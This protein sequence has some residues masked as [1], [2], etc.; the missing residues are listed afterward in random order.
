MNAA[1][2]IV[3]IR[4]MLDAGV[5]F[6]HR[7]KR[8]NPKM[9]PYIYMARSGIYIIHL[10]KT[11][12]LFERAYAFA[13]ELSARGEYLV[14]IGTKKQA[15][16]IVKEEAERC[17]MFYVNVRWLGGTLTN[18]KTV[19]ESIRRLN[20]LEAI[21][22]NE[23]YQGRP[24]KEILKIQKE[25]A[26][27]NKQLGGIKAMGEFLDKDKLPGAIFVIDAKKEAIAIKEA[28]RLGI[29]IIALVDTN[30]DPTDIDYVIPGNDDAI[31]SIRLF[32]SR[33]ADACIEGQRLYR[34][35]LQAS[36]GRDYDREKRRITSKVEV[37]YRSKEGSEERPAET[38]PP[39]PTPRPAPAETQPPA[40]QATKETERPPSATEPGA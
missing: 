37:T 11:A 20:Q 6:G 27:L 4:E 15:Q 24:K 22:K 7:T 10:Q 40:P 23:D 35:R 18:Y 38:Q 3:S 8:W 5:H 32:T 2:R 26:K 34:E 19:R 29:P 14:F 13:R 36:P 17:G 21:V 39:L 16:D 31:R 1:R 12:R 28:K 33:I 25:Y 30:C 9:K